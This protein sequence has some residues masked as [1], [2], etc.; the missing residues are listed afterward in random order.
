MPKLTVEL[1]VHGWFI[2]TNHSTGR[3]TFHPT[4]ISLLEQVASLA[5]SASSLPE[6]PPPF[7]LGIYR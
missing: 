7:R 1:G 5:N 2:L 4:L 3:V 6:A